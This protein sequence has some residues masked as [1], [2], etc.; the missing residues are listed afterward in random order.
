MSG[1]IIAKRLREE[2]GVEFL[3]ET[4]TRAQYRRHG[5]DADTFLVAERTTALGHRYLDTYV[6][7]RWDGWQGTD[8]CLP[9]DISAKRLAKA[10][11]KLTVS[12]FGTKGRVLQ[13]GIIDSLDGFEWR[14]AR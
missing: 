5:D 6:P 2:F 1:A 11:L 8:I 12:E 10:D 3:Q 9:L 13:V 7:W 4:P 14:I